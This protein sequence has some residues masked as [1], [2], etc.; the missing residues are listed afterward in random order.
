MSSLQS[1]Y[2]RNGNTQTVTDAEANTTSYGYDPLDG[3]SKVTDPLGLA[4]VIFDPDSNTRTFDPEDGSP[5][6]FLC[7]LEMMW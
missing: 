3:L 7:L 5:A 4:V 6:I 1:T 2:D